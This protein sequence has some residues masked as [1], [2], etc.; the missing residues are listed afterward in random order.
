MDRD[1]D[2]V[3]D[4]RAGFTAEEPAES[5]E[6]GEIETRGGNARGGIVLDHQLL[7][8]ADAGGEF[9]GLLAQ[10]DERNHFEE[11]DRCMAQA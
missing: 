3:L 7:P 8:E 11:Y 4:E 5:D 9:Q 1:Q 6:E 2:Q 10:P